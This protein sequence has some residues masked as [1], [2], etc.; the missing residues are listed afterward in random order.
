AAMLPA[1]RRCRLGP[2]PL[3]ALAAALGPGPVPGLCPG[4]SPRAVPAR[5]RKTRH[6]PPAKS[7]AGRVKLPP[8][9]DPEELLVVQER[10]RQYR[11][12]L[13]ALRYRH[14]PGMGMGLAKPRCSGQPPAF[15]GVNVTPHPS[16]FSF[17]SGREERARKEEEEQKRRKLETAEKQA[18]KME[19][20]LEEKEKEVLQLQ[21]EAKNFITPENLEARIEECLDNPQNYNFAIDKDGRIVKRTVLS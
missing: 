4:W 15:L 13:S 9:V 2:V 17:L 6:D 19:A 21:E 20:F 1:L 7:K 14:G 5:G 12:V 18:R 3:P 8:P 16:D 11:L 10:Y